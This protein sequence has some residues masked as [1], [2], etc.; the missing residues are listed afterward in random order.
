M[1]DI[2][3]EMMTIIA[4]DFND[5][6]NTLTEEEKKEYSKIIDDLRDGRNTNNTRNVKKK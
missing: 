5:W 3:K 2:N 1:R 6:Y 4:K